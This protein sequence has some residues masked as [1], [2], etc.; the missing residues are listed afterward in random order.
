MI[1][2][3]GK[4]EKKKE[5]IYSADELEKALAAL[6]TGQSLGA[7]S[8]QYNIPKSTLHDKSKGRTAASVVKKGPPCVLGAVEEAKLVQWIIAMGYRGFAI[9]K[10]QLLD[11][12][13]LHV[14]TR[15]KQTVFARN[16]P[17]RFWYTGFLQRHPE[18]Y[19]R[20]SH[21]LTTN[22]V[23]VTEEKIR[24]WFQRTRTYL[25][26]Q[27]LL[28]ID[29]SRIFNCDDSSFRL[30]PPGHLGLTEKKNKAVYN[31]V[32]NDDK[33]C[34]TV[35]FC[36]NARGDLVPPMVMFKYA[37]IPA[38][39][40]TRMPKGWGI[41]RSD[42]GWMT[43]I[44]FYEWVTK[45][46]HPWLIQNEIQ[47]PVVLF[48]DG[49]TSHLSLELSNFCRQHKIEMIPLYP[50]S[51]HITQPWNVSCFGP[52]K[53]AWKKEVFQWRLENNGERMKKEQFGMILKSAVD[54][55]DWRSILPRAFEATGLH[56]FRPD[57]INFGKHLKNTN[58]QTTEIQKSGLESEQSF[59]VKFESF[60]DE[61]VLHQ[62]QHAV[63]NDTW[64]GDETLTGLFNYWKRIKFQGSSTHHCATS[65]PEK[66]SQ[67]DCTDSHEVFFRST[68][69]S[70]HVL[71]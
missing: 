66:S 4:I 51:T 15:R 45:I 57:G 23:A 55:L 52:L 43:A 30:C 63:A 46:F 22:R 41:G 7:V 36:G 6:R 44:S 60:L 3:R 5:Q 37:R 61:D 16:R 10:T 71:F 48:I 9:T 70:P 27:N 65:N 64:T 2:C 69:I 32:Q 47:F 25:E 39:V 59:L 49:H 50:N 14:K 35:L 19:Q 12:V 11:C 17:G 56:P 8:K 18:L 42:N 54:T 26:E 58:C 68:Q 20:L 40:A 28:E 1:C 13:Q 31:Y 24:D 38:S 33:E 67:P 62:F 29:S 53:D 34:Q 21:N